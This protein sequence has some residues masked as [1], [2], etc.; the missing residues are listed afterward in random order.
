M[1][2]KSC[3]RRS[4]SLALLLGVVL[5]APIVLPYLFIKTLFGI[6]H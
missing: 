6:A 5:F 4:S 3:G 2:H 1:R